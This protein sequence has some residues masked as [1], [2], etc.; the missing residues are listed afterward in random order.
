MWQSNF[1]DSCVSDIRLCRRYV[2]FP[3]KCAWMSVLAQ[4]PLP[5][6]DCYRVSAFHPK[7]FLFP[8]PSFCLSSWTSFLMALRNCWFMHF[9][10][11]F[12]VLFS[13]CKQFR[14]AAPIR[15]LLTALF[16]FLEQERPCSS[17]FAFVY[18]LQRNLHMCDFNNNVHILCFVPQS[19]REKKNKILLHSN[20]DVEHKL[21]I[22]RLY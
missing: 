21:Q 17:N 13:S 5:S 4:T 8:F 19:E 10:I 1:Y 9:E 3:G 2:S 22:L 12:N 16:C 7:C 20:W 15:H 6:W 18:N 11:K 14:S